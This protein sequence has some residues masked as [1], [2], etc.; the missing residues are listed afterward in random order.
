MIY[1]YIFKS[2]FPSAFVLFPFCPLSILDL[3]Q[4][5]SFYVLS[6]F[7]APNMRDREKYSKLKINEGK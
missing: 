5:I 3:R 4:E 6:R 2:M 7:I 1:S